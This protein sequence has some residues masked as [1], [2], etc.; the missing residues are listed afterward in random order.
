MFNNVYST[1][2]R[3]TNLPFCAVAPKLVRLVR[4]NTKEVLF[5]AFFFLKLGNIY[6]ILVLIVIHRTYE[7]EVFLGQGVETPC[8]VSLYVTMGFSPLPYFF[9]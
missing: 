1:E 8:Y 2:S 7:K 5:L 4:K 9:S 3:T 6:A